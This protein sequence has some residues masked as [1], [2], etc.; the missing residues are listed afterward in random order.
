MWRNVRS[1][2]RHDVPSRAASLR[3]KRAA[4]AHRLGRRSRRTGTVLILV[5]ILMIVFVAMAAFAIDLGVRVQH[6]AAL[7]KAVDAAALAG[8][9][10]LERNGFAA[11][12]HLTRAVVGQ[13]FAQNQPAL[14]PEV[15]LGRWNRITR[16][17]TP[18]V[19]SP[20]AINA[21]RVQAAWQY[22][23]LF[24]KAL[25]A[26]TYR[27]TAE[28]V[29]IG[30]RDVGGPR[31]IVLLIDQTAALL[32][33]H[34]DAYA[35]GEQ[36][37]HDYPL[38]AKRAL[39]EAALTFIDDTLADFPDD[40]IA[41][42][43]FAEHTEVERALTRN[44]AA[45]H[46]AFDIDR[47]GAFIY[48]HAEYQAQSGGR[49]PGAIPRL[50]LALDGDSEGQMGGRQI[51]VGVNARHDAKKM[52]ILVSTGDTDPQPDPQAIVA[53]LAAD[54]FDIYTITTGAPSA[55][56][57]SLA[58]GDGRNYVV[59]ASAAYATMLAAFHEAFDRIGG[60]Q[61]THPKLVK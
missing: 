32:T 58:V 15:E 40:Q 34:P 37:P 54:G 9:G 16:T 3:R 51:A 12:E 28:S 57:R 18:N 17:F 39:R 26:A 11:N 27:S 46:G 61:P 13:Y 14:T 55:L 47:P 56:M 43:G 20:L 42:S 10:V 30:G 44:S 33:P 41:V 49:Y 25:G 22:D 38:N 19:T 6:R 21:V 4:R 53:Q 7:Q 59:P 50:G 23:S 48:A 8:V 35:P 52:L 45:L 29:A 2:S 24:G 36:A 60:R 1:H 31:D 5:A